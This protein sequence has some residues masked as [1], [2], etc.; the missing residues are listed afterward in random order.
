[1]LVNA[2]C[3]N[4]RQTGAPVSQMATFSYSALAALRLILPLEVFGVARGGART[5]SSASAPLISRTISCAPAT[6]RARLRLSFRRFHEHD[7]ALG[8]GA[9]IERA[10]RRDA[11]PAHAGNPS[12]SLLDLL[13]IE[14]PTRAD[15]D[16]LDATRDEYVATRDIGAVATVEPAVADERARLFL[17]AVIARRRGGS[18]K[19]QSPF[20]VLADFTAA[21]VDD[22]D[23][24][25]IERLSAGDEL[26]GFGVGRRGGGETL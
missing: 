22:A 14:M 9:R 23:F 13:R 15:D 12:D 19:L 2:R 11:T 8:A 21:R 10:E 16:I 6:I 4:C 7:E 20:P 17:V 25:A 26:H 24:V 3:A 5:I 1:M 18:T